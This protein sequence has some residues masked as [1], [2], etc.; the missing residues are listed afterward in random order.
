MPSSAQVSS[1]SPLSNTARTQPP[2][3]YPSYAA[4]EITGGPFVSGRYY[5]LQI[6][7]FRVA[8]NAVEAFD[9]LSAAGLN[10]QWEPFG[11]LY[12]VVISN[13]RSDEVNSIAVKL[14]NAG[15]KEA[16]AREER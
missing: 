3:A 11:E 9:R 10:P 13:V 8:K 1:I 7:S 4:A 16:I 15:F 6:G 12:R 14:G 2:R 5:R